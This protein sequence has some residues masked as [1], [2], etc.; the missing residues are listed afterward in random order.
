MNNP[1]IY[2]YYNGVDPDCHSDAFSVLHF[3]GYSILAI[4][5]GFIIDLL[6]IYFAG[7]TSVD[8]YSNAIFF[9]LYLLQDFMLVLIVPNTAWLEIGIIVI[10]HV[11]FFLLTLWISCIDTAGE[12]VPMMS[13]K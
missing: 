11:I 4:I 8:L 9:T 12:M 10:I 5:Q 13:L 1:K 2:R 7:N 6:F 3:I